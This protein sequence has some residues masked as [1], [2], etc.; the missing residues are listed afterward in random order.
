[1]EA[2][3][4]A[5][6][7]PTEPSKEALAEARRMAGLSIVEWAHALDRFRAA[8]VREERERCFQWAIDRIP[9]SAAARSIRDGDPAGEVHTAEPG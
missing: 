5:L 3:L 2:D 8:G 1:M 6:E 7:T 4:T 9:R